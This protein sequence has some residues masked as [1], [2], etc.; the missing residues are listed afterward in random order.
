MK[1]CSH[2]AGSDG[3]KASLM[4]KVVEGLGESL[5]LAEAFLADYSLDATV[6]ERSLKLV[7]E[8]S[9]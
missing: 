5:I 8:S 7:V 9:Q 4:F 1:H 3:S 2:T 6:T